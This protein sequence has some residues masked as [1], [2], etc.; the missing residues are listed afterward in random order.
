MKSTGFGGLIWRGISTPQAGTRKVSG[1][2]ASGEMELEQPSLGFRSKTS[3]LTANTDALQTTSY[4]PMTLVHYQEVSPRWIVKGFELFAKGG[5]H[6]AACCYS[7][8]EQRGCFPGGTIGLLRQ[9]SIRG[10]LNFDNKSRGPR[11]RTPHQ[12]AFHCCFIKACP[13]WSDYPHKH[14]GSGWPL[15]RKTV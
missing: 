14:I 15:F 8:S 4:L 1:V 12:W 11:K 2:T 6:S 10:D 13:A 3:H 9:C 5:S 7:P